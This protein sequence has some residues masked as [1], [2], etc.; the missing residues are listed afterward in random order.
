MRLRNVL[1]CLACVL[2]ALPALAQI[3]TSTLRGQVSNE[4]KGLPGVTVSV[5]SPNLQGARTTV[6]TN[7]GD[8]LLP[9]LPPGDYAVKFEL[10]GFQTLERNV[11]L[12]AAQTTPLDINMTVE[13]VSEEIVVTGTAETIS[14]TPQASTT[15]EK[16]LIE[17]LPIAR[18]I[19][20]TVLLAPGVSSTGPS[21]SI[22]I[23]GSQ[24]YENLFL[25][26]GVV[27]NEN[28]RGQPFTLFIEDAIQ[29]TT[30]TSSSVSAEYGRFGG[31]V[32]N[33]IT[34]SGGNDVH[35]SFRDS[36][37]NDRW[38][39]P[40]ARTITRT[41]KINNRYEATLGGYFLKD[42]LWYFGAGRKFTQ[43]LTGTTLAP[44]GGSASV[45]PIVN[46]EKRY[47]GK[48][49]LSPFEGHRIIGSYIKIDRSEAG[50]VFGNVLDLASIVNRSLPQ[51]LEA[52]NYT[53]I[54]TD[55]FFAEA[56]Y[57]KRSFSFIGSGATS[58]DRIN[59]TLLLERATG[60]RFH[61]PTFCGVCTPEARDNNNTVLKG[62]YFLSNDTIGAHDMVFGYDTF[63]DI[64][65]A[66]NHQSGSDFRIYL[67]GYV[68]Q[69]G[70]IFPS[71]IGGPGATSTYIQYNPIL[72]SS[73]GTSFK[74]NSLFY[75]D[76]WRFND[77]WSFNIG[78]RYDKNDGSDSQGRK[79]A[80]DSR[81]SPRLAAAW[82]PKG[83]GDWVVNLGASQYVT[84]IANSQAD[85][86]SQGGN[87]AQIRYWYQ[88]PNINVGGGPLVP[89]DVAIK[90]IFDWFDSLGGTNPN[91]RVPIRDIFIPG[92][93]TVIR[94]SLESPYTQELSLGVTKRLGTRGVVRAD[95]IRR[96]SKAF[97]SIRTDL[98]T[99]AV[100]TS[101]G[102]TDRSILE[103][104]NNL[105]RQYTGLHTQFQYRFTDRLS[106]GG[107]YTLSELKGDVD[108]ETANN[109]PIAAGDDSYAQYFSKSFN[110]PKGDLT[111][112]QRHRVRIWGV[113]DLF[114][115]SHNA[116]NVSILQNYYSGTP[117]GIVG[118][119]DTRP[120]VANPGFQSPPSVV[121]Y[122]F[123]ARDAFR[124]SNIS[125]TDLALNY[126]FSLN[127]PFNKSYEIFFEPEILNV[128]DYHGLIANNTTVFDATTTP[129]RCPTG[130]SA[131]ADGTPGATGF[132]PFNPFT[133][134]PKKGP[135]GSGAN[136]QTS[137]A[138][139]RPRSPLDY[140]TPRTFRFSVGIR[141]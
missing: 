40:T 31:G 13:K 68:F 91:S 9:L 5:T 79:V 29:E 20:N 46:D 140:Q 83:N 130:G 121:T 99:G 71:A 70:Q 111:A 86:T 41:D 73:R 119:V 131:C 108:G 35:A 8:Y 126:S 4:N 112:D 95:L 82:D 127:G 26:N 139:G 102:P 141:F 61:A 2:V 57:S 3:P 49:T 136:Y 69:N 63:D 7:G 129:F 115:N 84:A 123:S 58:T 18:D 107:T 76:K 55:K 16:K 21:Q 105:Q 66:D 100:N 106:L 34:K 104:S 24:S 124:T 122:Y 77:H 65:K 10:Q 56:Q 48:L 60:F 17:E 50:N 28:L 78:A 64:R 6:T 67:S 19:V 25:V 15:Y 94:G 39:A 110:N 90:Q 138:F 43:T 47:E 118:G 14:V 81:V 62:S 42:R 128:L 116:L 87:P 132:R 54:F 92:D 101:S 75:N 27:V 11:T 89:A 23:S 88:G 36:L 12:A 1:L 74:T 97:Y 32:V 93:T 134:T 113:F 38:T 59:G 98:T 109:G 120:Y 72:I 96:D 114:K 51:K 85:S 117:Y 103:N 33:T 30:V 80:K 52:V 53:G 133:T 37:T 137:V 125:A 22:T 135:S 44:V 45:Y